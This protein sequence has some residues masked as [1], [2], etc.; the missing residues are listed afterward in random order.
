MLGELGG[1][2]KRHEIAKML[3][4]GGQCQR[5]RPGDGQGVA[6]AHSDNLPL[7]E[8]APGCL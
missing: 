1:R 8:H 6:H 4:L 7:A 2:V 3:V 5:L